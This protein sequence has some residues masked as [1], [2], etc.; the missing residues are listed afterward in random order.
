M[1]TPPIL[2]ALNLKTVGM[3]PRGHMAGV[4]SSKSCMQVV[5]ATSGEIWQNA[6]PR[7]LLFGKNG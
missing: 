4:I 1:I 3:G 2:G 6:P 7:G 5:S